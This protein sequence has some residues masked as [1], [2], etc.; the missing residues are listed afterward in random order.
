MLL[1]QAKIVLFTALLAG[2]AV[3]LDVEN[4]NILIF[5]PYFAHSHYVFHN[6]LAD[7]LSNEGYNVTVVIPEIDLETAVKLPKKASVLTRS[8]MISPFSYQSQKL[9]WTTTFEMYKY[10]Q[11]YKVFHAH[12]NGVC[13][14]LF[15]DTAFIETLKGLKF[16]FA[17]LEPLDLCGFGLLQLLGINNYAIASP[18]PITE[19][20]AYALG[21]PGRRYAVNSRNYDFHP[22]L[23]F[24]E[25][26][27]NIFSAMFYYVMQPHGLSLKA[28]QKYV[29]P[30]FNS[31]EIFTKARYVFA[32][33]DEFVDF[34]RPLNEKVVYIG[35]ITLDQHH[36]EPLP[37]HYKEILENSKE[38]VVLV[39]FGSLAKASAMPDEFKAAF[40]QMFSAFPTVDFIWKYENASDS[41]L[42]N[43]A[44]VHF[45]NWIP[46]K[47]ILAHPKTLAFLSHG[48]MNSV[49]EAAYAGVPLLG[50]PLFA[51]QLRN[52]KMLEYRKTGL[53]VRKTELTA[54]KLI[55]SMSKL[56]SKEFQQNANTLA[57]LVDNKPQSGKDRFI[58][59][60]R[61]AV[62]FPDIHDYLDFEFRKVSFFR[63]HDLDVYL[64][65]SVVIIGSFAALA[66]LF[67][68]IYQ[69][70][71]GVVVKD[72][73][74]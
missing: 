50:I 17:V 44:N 20:C 43:L 53:V 7:M 72:K 71:V 66:V 38:G 74:D 52:G 5:N 22:N 54:E 69:V 4:E 15:A 64:M 60:I 1:V 37:A 73:R 33:T 42:T 21:F 19:E 56:L 18:M 65:F 2:Y 59:H 67:R 8:P 26:A 23:S 35:G 30:G 32:N 10:S 12:N 3:G 68:T 6:V 14:R 46:Q 39:S 11:F 28:I 48:G 27:E 57:K 41:I 63:Y 36:L 16:T 58:K 61:H 70:L 40:V 9:F 45:E 25:R 47:E 34:P 13:E 31:L 49:L 24:Y 29:D 51:D 55:S 62:M